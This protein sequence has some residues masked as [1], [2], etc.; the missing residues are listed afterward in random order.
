MTRPRCGNDPRAELTDG[1]H[2]AVAGFKAYLADRAALRD[3]IAEALMRWAERGNSPQYAAMRQP[4]TVRANA[5]S[6]ADAVLAVLPPPADRAAVLREAADHLA[7]QADELW[8]PGTTAH[9]VMHAD[10]TE[11]RRMADETPATPAD[12]EH[13]THDRAVHT[14]HHQQPVPGCP[15]C[16][17]RD[18]A[19]P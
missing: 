6:R 11:L 12:V 4:E 19:T 18:E 9:T 10:A 1:D 17:P 14:R 16:A 7:R 5:Y 3:H 8:A 13:C 2:Q 15:W